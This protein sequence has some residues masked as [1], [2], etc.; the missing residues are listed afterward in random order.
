MGVSYP[1]RPV[2]GV[3]AVI[4]KQDQVLLVRR[5][6]PPGQGHWSLPG[7]TV[8]L[9]ESLS[10]AVAREVMEE[11]GLQ[12]QAGPLLEVVEA[13]FPDANGHIQY[14]YILFDYLCQVN[15]GQLSPGSDAS[16]AAW[17]APEQ[18]PQLELW[19]ETLRIIRKGLEARKA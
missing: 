7:G 12:V 16:Q 8:E 1:E 5:A 2:V 11:T 18:L 13:V 4:L 10:Q 6:Q 15:G 14:H 3:G 9:G 17:F 19:P